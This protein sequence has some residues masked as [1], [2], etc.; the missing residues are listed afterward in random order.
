MTGGKARLLA[1]AVLAVLLGLSTPAAAGTATHP[2]EPDMTDPA[3]CLAV[4]IYW[5]AMGET[6]TGKRAVGSVIMNRVRSPDFPDTVCGVVTEGGEQGPCQ[7]SFWCDGRSDH[8][9]ERGPWRDARAVARELLAGRGLDPTLGA[10]YF[11]NGT[12]MPAWTADLQE[13]ARIGDHW[14]YR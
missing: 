14:F 7:F 2:M 6:L 12:V 11:H 8:P 4:A 3:T 13:T 10:L 9:V 5:E 1:G